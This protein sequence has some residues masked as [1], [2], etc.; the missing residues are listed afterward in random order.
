MT[1]Q[2]YQKNL[3][4]VIIIAIL[5]FLIV[6]Y[7]GNLKLM[8]VVSGGEMF[9][10]NWVG[11]RTFLVNGFSPYTQES[12]YQIQQQ[13]ALSGFNFSFDGWHS[14]E[15]LYGLLIYFPFLLIKSFTHAF[16]AW[17]AFNE[18]LLFFT[19]WLLYRVVEWKGSRIIFVFAAITIIFWKSIIDVLISGSNAILILFAL[20][21]VL[22]TLKF[23]MDELA[24]VLLAIVSIKIHLLWLPIIFILVYTAIQ[25]K[26]KTS[27]WFLASILLISVS[28][29]LLDPGWIKGYFVSLL[30]VI[31]GNADSVVNAS[32]FTQLFN[33]QYFS[34]FS[35]GLGTIFL[36]F[37]VRLG[38][39]FSILIAILMIIEWFSIQK[40]DFKG[41]LWLFSLTMIISTWIGVNDK[42]ALFIFYLP[43]FILSLSLIY[44]RWQ[45]KGYLIYWI[46]PLL[47]LVINWMVFSTGMNAIMLVFG[48]YPLLFF[49]ILYWIRWWALSRNYLV[50]EWKNL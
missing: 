7:I 37:G 31:L 47:I 11:A 6:L 23:N 30:T 35:K 33:D 25:G 12:L 34:Y 24:G 29:M 20:I 5:I 19:F 1:Y 42:S 2:K 45:E 4:T 10:A 32:S 13:N 49:V 48:F 22:Y 44:D 46:L 15:P 9:F 21:A 50:Y 16:A 17:L 38:N 8:D 39:V 28:L 27:I 40:R 41:V 3:I 18:I 14:A 26:R 43:V 36:S